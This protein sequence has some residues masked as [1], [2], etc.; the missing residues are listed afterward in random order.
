MSSKGSTKQ[1]PLSY[2]AGTGGFGRYLELLESDKEAEFLR[3]L[4]VDIA[5]EQGY[6]TADDLREFIVSR[7]IALKKSYNI[8]GAVLASLK[9]KGVLKIV[10][11]EPSRVP[12]S[13]ARPIAVYVLAEKEKSG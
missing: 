12:T 11:Y 1:M 6:V 4:A 5:K 2:F 10:G 7:G 13:H 8:F 9:R 3:N